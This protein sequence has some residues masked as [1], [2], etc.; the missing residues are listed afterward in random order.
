LL[1]SAINLQEPDE[2][3]DPNILIIDGTSSPLEELSAW[4]VSTLVYGMMLISGV[5]MFLSI[6]V[7]SLFCP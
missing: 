4:V 6:K 1:F 5:L 7:I 2:P 3:G